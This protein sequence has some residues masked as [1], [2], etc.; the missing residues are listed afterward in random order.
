MKYEWRKK[1]KELYM[2]STHPI[3]VT[4]PAM[5]YLTVEGNGHPGGEMFTECIEA[6]YGMSY[7]IKMSPKGGDAPEGYYEYTVF[8]LEGIWSLDKKGI[9]KY[10]EGTLIIDLKHHLAYKLMI[11]QPEFVQND[12]VEVVRHKVMEKKSNSKLKEVKLEQLEEGKCVQMLHIGSYDLEPRS[13]ELME[14][15]AKDE[16]LVRKGKNHKEIY[17]SDVR[18]V[19]QDKL[20]TTLRFWVEEV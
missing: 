15:F 7:G 18:R 20:K 14:Q 1:D 13:F 3:V 8:P 6:L 10:K 12:F 4:V 17:I 5:Q 9:E 16:G 2:P 19:S 11:R